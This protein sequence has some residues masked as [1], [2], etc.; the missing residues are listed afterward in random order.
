MCFICGMFLCFEEHACFST[1]SLSS[2]LLFHVIRCAVTSCFILIVCFPLCVYSLMYCAAVEFSTFVKD[3]Q[4]N[5]GLFFIYLVLSRIWVL[6]VQKTNLF[7]PVNH[8]I[9]WKLYMYSHLVIFWDSITTY[10]SSCP[11][12]CSSHSKE[13]HNIS[14]T[15]C[16]SV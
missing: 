10:F 16:V 1:L 9:Q 13:V 5:Q 4:P 7:Y 2:L 15:K 3:F 8:R 14:S 11:A 6:Q 12:K